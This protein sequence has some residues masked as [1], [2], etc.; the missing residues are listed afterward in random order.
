MARKTGHSEAGVRSQESGADL[1]AREDQREAREKCRVMYGQWR[2]LSM[3]ETGTCSCFP[4]TVVPPIEW[5][6]DRL[7]EDGP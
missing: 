4:I 3:E 6:V 2:V 1:E 7:G 5:G